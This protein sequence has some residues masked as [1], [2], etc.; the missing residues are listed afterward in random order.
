MKNSLLLFFIV[1]FISCSSDDS[2]SNNS[3]YNP[4]SWIH[5]TWGLAKTEFSDE[6]PFYKF[7]SDNV[8]QL[9]QV[10]SLCWKESVMDFPQIHSGS[11][12]SSDT[13]YES[14]FVSVGGTTITLNFQKVSSSKI[15]WLN[16]GSSEIELVKLK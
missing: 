6:N 16:S 10:S 7:T 11:D 15:L 1:A 13:I 4:P 12:S 14:K 3:P 5:G 8:C 2:S 9:T